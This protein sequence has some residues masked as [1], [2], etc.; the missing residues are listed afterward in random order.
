[1]CQKIIVLGASGHAK[2]IADIVI[3][4]GN[5][6]EGFLDDNVNIGKI[7]LK[8]DEKEYKVLGKVEKSFELLRKDINIKFVIGIGDNYIRE[9]IASKYV[10]PYITLVHP[11]AVISVGVEIGNGTVVMPNA[12]V[13]VGAAIGKHCIINTGAIVEHDNII[14]D[15]VHISPNAT[16]AGTVN[17]GNYTHIRNWCMY[18]K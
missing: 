3:K 18:K 13:N 6:L 12:V 17:V 5:I 1:M 4:S 10:L 16:L 9:K 14:K 2:V 7:I 11:K 15:Y 8:Y